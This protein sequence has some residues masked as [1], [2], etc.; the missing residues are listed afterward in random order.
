M[1]IKANI[2]KIFFIAL[3]SVMGIGMLI[4][5][6]A[7]INKRNSKTCKGLRVEIVDKQDPVFVERGDIIKMLAVDNAA[8]PEG[9][10]IS[11]FHLLKIEEA[12]EKNPWVKSAE[13]FFDNN[14]MLRINI[15]QRD[16]VARIFTVG[17]NNFFMDS[18]GVQLPFSDKAV[19]KLPVFTGFPSEK[20]KLTGADGQLVKQIKKIDEYILN[21]PFWSAQ[22]D[23]I[24]IKP[25]RTFEMVPVVGN[26]VIVFG[27]G[28]DY[29]KKFRHLFIFYK[30]VLS[31]TGFDK[32]ARVDVQYNGE[33]LG[34]KKDGLMKKS[35]S[36]QA[37]KI[38]AQLIRSA[39]QMQ[40]DTVKQRVVRPL[41][42]SNGDHEFRSGDLDDSVGA[43]RKN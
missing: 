41:E 35:D 31:K 26:H 13:V 15:T 39:Q 42:N 32:Y 28:N 36:L 2:R 24:D 17:G 10:A 22:I 14:D 27:D 12:I 21:N 8:K 18:S 23:Q 9:K 30:Q 1:S 37:A 3:W 11:D 40:A 20:I 5:L 25:D 19:L 6:V 34:V 16:P 4:L 38:I 7:A 29:E 43:G 33:V